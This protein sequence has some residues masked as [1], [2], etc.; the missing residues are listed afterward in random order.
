MHEEALLALRLLAGP[1]LA[2]Q[3]PQLKAASGG[4][5]S[6][7]SSSSSSSSSSASASS[8]QQQ[9][10]ELAASLGHHLHQQP[11]QDLLALAVLAATTADVYNAC[12][13]AASASQA[14]A[15]GGRQPPQAPL[16]VQ[17]RDVLRLLGVLAVN[18]I[19]VTPP[20][21]SS[22][23]DR[24]AL[25]LYPAVALAN[26]SCSPS[27]SLSFGTVRRPLA[28]PADLARDR[29]QRLA[30]LS[31][32]RAGW[33]WCGGGV[34]GLHAWVS[35]SLLNS[36]AARLQGGRLALVAAQGLARGQEACISYGPQQGQAPRQAR[37][38]QLRQQYSFE[39]RCAACGGGDGGAAAAHGD[40]A[41][42]G[43]RCQQG[44]CSG[45]VL[46]PAE[47]PEG[48]VAVHPLRGGGR[49]AECGAQAQAVQEAMGR[50]AKA[51]E[52]HT[53]AQDLLAAAEQLAPG[54][55]ARPG[56]SCGDGGRGHSSSA[57]LLPPDAGLH[58][59][60]RAVPGSTLSEEAVGQLGKQRAS[61]VE[62]KLQAA[63]Q[64]LQACIAHRTSSLHPH[65]MLL[66]QA[67][68]LAAQVAQGVAACQGSPAAAGSSWWRRAAEHVGESVAVLQRHYPAGAPALL[69]QQ[70]W[71]AQLRAG[72]EAA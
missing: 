69:T 31:L 66:A 9:R 38:Q 40:A 17:A 13:A 70:A 52:Q 58:H 36:A 35:A 5:S 6:A 12:A 27:C 1:A 59:G 55:F 37:Q 20:L 22:P 63:A 71:L 60:S 42:C 41:M 4:S 68:D 54:V 48:L 47:L 49:C 26:H 14:A 57:V 24:L 28:R 62:S 16:Q 64:L 46:P 65:I 51:Q 44:G 25:G 11:A 50:L 3:G 43:L 67:H 21:C 7:S 2:L 39:C 15:S 56:E 32:L 61:A 33:G 8:G 29:S 53:E 72:L 30:Q 34:V 18:G 10:R 23:A 19:A 45:A